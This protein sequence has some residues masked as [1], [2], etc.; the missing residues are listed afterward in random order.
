LR[1][2]TNAASVPPTIAMSELTATRPEIL[3][4]VCALMTLK[5]NQ[6]TDRIHAPSARNGI[7]DGGCADIPPAFR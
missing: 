1:P 4:S 3:S 6:P 7:D 2:A 5:P